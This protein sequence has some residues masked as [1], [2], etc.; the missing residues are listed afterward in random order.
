MMT[1][2]LSIE[3]MTPVDINDVRRIETLSFA[4]QWPSDAFYNEL[5][6][7]RSAHYYVGRVSGRV[8]AYGGIWVVMEDSH[9]TTIAVDPD[10]RGRKFGEILLAHL[11]DRAIEREAAWMTLEVR[12]TNVG[13]QQLYRKYGFTTVATRKA[14]YSDNNESALV[15]WAGDLRGELYRERLKAMRGSLEK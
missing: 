8:V 12:E 11:I 15:M 1:A 10:F 6:S 2:G 4:T 3:T 14:Y 7:N 5:Q 13:A 9:I